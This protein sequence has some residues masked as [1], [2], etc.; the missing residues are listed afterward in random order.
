VASISI[1]VMSCGVTPVVT[2]MSDDASVPG[3]SGAT[4]AVTIHSSHAPGGSAVA[5]ASLPSAITVTPSTGTFD[6]SGNATTIAL[7]PYGVS[8]YVTAVVDRVTLVE[9]AVSAPP[10]SLCLSSESGSGPDADVTASGEIREI[11]VAATTSGGCPDGAAAPAGIS[12][13][14]GVSQSP[15]ASSGMSASVIAA[16][17]TDRKGI[18]TTVVSIPWGTQTIFEATAGGASVLIPLQAPQSP[19]EISCISWKE[20]S[21]I[22]QVSA[23]A[24]DNQV[25][26]SSVP[27]TFAVLAPDPKIVV[28]P[29]PTSTNDAGVAN[30][31]LAGPS[32]GGSLVVEAFTGTS[33][34]TATI[35]DAGIGQTGDCR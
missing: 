18:A 35:G 14:F 23:Q 34:L 12:V 33:M 10:L 13:S 32:A 27:V 9:V 25:P 24:V 2:G 21:G 29:S 4:Q 16:A 15:G 11:E 28:S 19:I 31:V 1:L 30:A 8:G 5:F 26:I 3:P 17:V 20:V 22:V 6:A 7:V